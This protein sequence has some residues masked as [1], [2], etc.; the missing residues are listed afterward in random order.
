MKGSYTFKEADGTVRV[1]DYIA[2]PHGGFNAVVKRIGHAYHPQHYGNKYGGYDGH[3]GGAYSHV[4]T[5]HFG[6]HY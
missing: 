3:S 1:V 4:G 5:T 6:Y 2:G